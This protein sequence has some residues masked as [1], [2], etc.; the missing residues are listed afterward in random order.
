MKSDYAKRF[1]KKN[2]EGKRLTLEDKITTRASAI[3]GVSLDYWRE[4]QLI[5]DLP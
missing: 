3:V 2:Y 5:D 4:C 1:G